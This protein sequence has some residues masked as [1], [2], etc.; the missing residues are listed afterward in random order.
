MGLN[1]LITFPIGIM[2]FIAFLGLVLYLG[3][4]I[5]T[6][7]TSTGY[8]GFGPG[9]FWDMNA[10]TTLVAVIAGVVILVIAMNVTFFGIAILTVTP[11]AQIMILKGVVYFGLFLTFVG[12]SAWAFMSFG[13]WGTVAQ[14]MLTAMLA[15]GYVM[16]IREGAA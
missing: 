1:K 4:F 16:D 12:F 15:L 5:A 9:F 11:A 10:L 14:G 13:I 8:S 6:P 7:G 3:G 2:G